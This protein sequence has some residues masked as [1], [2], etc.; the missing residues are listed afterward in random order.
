MVFLQLQWRSNRRSFCGSCCWSW[1]NSPCFLDKSKFFYPQCKWNH[2]RYCLKFIGAIEEDV[3]SFL[4]LFLL[5]FL[6]SRKFFHH[7]FHFLLFF[8]FLSFFIFILSFPTPYSFLSQNKSKEII[9]KIKKGFFSNWKRRKSIAEK[10][11]LVPLFG[12]FLFSFSFCQGET[13]PF[14]FFC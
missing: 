10:W 3:S 1:I 14:F 5:L 11:I 6:L 12:C 2:D 7:H 13:K 9:T 8:C 4:F